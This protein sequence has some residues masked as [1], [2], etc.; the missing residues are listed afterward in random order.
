MVFARV[1]RRAGIDPAGVV[2]YLLRHS[3]VSLLID[4]GAPI[5]EVADLLG[6]DPDRLPP[7]PPPR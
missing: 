7:L 1:A 5:E 3:V 2:P 6:D 4:A